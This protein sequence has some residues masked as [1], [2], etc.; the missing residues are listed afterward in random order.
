MIGWYHTHPNLGA[1]FSG[2]DET[3]QRSFFN[4]SYSLGLVI[5][6]AR[7]EKKI[8]FGASSEEYPFDCVMMRDGMAMV[9]QGEGVRQCEKAISGE[10]ESSP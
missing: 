2:T 8:F 3:T 4:Q 6:P 1:F 5:D 10:S 9:Y 7:C